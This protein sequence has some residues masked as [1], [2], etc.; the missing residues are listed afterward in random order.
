MDP[1]TNHDTHDNGIC[2]VHNLSR[3]KLQPQPAYYLFQTTPI[4]EWL[5]ENL[6]PKNASQDTFVISKID[7]RH[8]YCK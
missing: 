7:F 6:H 5:H 1:G 8:N 3:L 4:H 2:S